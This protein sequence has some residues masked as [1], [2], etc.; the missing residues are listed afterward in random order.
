MWLLTAHYA[1]NKGDAKSNKI[2]LYF[3]YIDKDEQGES[4]LASD[5]LDAQRWYSHNE[6]VSIE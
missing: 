2:L 5:V 1:L 3:G 6:K 4:V